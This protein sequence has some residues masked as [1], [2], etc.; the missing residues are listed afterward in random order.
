[1][2]HL[3]VLSAVS[4]LCA[5]ASDANDADSGLPMP[6]ASMTYSCAQGQQF[7]V[8]MNDDGDVA[9]VTFGERQFELEKEETITG[10][11]YSDGDVIFWSKGD[12]GMLK[13]T[14][15]TV[16]TACTMTSLSG[17][18]PLKP[19]PTTPVEAAPVEPAPVESAPAPAPQ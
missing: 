5:C 7:S 8:Q 3:L 15:G 1:M 6:G 18:A 19:A 13:A 2:R 10:I 11:Q 17:I 12:A 14:G 4:L 16:L 9:N